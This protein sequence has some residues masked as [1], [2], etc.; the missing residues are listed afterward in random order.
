MKEKMLAAVFE[1]EGRL[2]LKEVPVPQ[3][4]K[5]DDVVL[6]VE[7]ASICGSDVSILSVPPKHPANVNTILGHE[8]VGRVI[9]TGKDVNHVKRGDTVVA[10]PNLSCGLCRYC[11]KGMPD[12]CENSTTLGI[13]VDGGFA[14]YSKAPAKALYKISKKVSPEQAVFVEPLSCV[15]NAIN[16][17][18]MKS[19]E[20]VVILGAG[21]MGLLF[22]QMVKVAGAGKII[23]SEISEPRAK[24][25][26]D[27]GASLV[28]NPQKEDLSSIVRGETGIGA[29]VVIDAV[30]TLLVDSLQIVRKSGRIL[31]FGLNEG[32]STPI[33]QFEITHNSITV[34]GSYI[35]RFNYSSAIAL[36]E[37]GVLNLGKLI[38]HR[39]P[40]K[41]I[42]KGI[43]LMRKG[44]AVKIILFPSNVSRSRSD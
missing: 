34:M 38:T 5:T 18:G 25:A 31:L 14:E 9:E 3:V 44:E 24:K 17:L 15:V 20:V 43:D 36:V 29:D 27:S 37:D 2:I 19:E 7:T 35:E 6:K 11:R 1:G 33:R 28:V 16:K 32:F 39:L 42:H 12:M 41:K 23:V 8:F 26:Y 13:F 10:A 22:V 40:L 4:E 30:G 21:P